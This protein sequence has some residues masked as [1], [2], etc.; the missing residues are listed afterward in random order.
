MHEA[1]TETPEQ[2]RARIKARMLAAFEDGLCNHFD[3]P[4]S[5]WSVVKGSTRNWH[6]VDRQGVRRDASSHQTKQAAATDLASGRYEKR[7]QADTDWYLGTSTDP[8]LRPLTPDERAV[9]DRVLG[10]RPAQGPSMFCPG[11]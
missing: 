3:N 11:E 5:T 6:I 1:Q 7:W 4:P 2:R 9:V 10:D 8:R